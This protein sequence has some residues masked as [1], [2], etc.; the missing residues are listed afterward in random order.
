MISQLLA[1][2]GE[3]WNSDKHPQ[4]CEVVLVSA[5]DFGQNFDKNK[6]WNTREKEASWLK[7]SYLQSNCVTFFGRHFSFSIDSGQNSGILS[8][9]IWESCWKTLKRTSPIDSADAECYVTLE[10]FI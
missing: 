10:G 4:D 9:L 3:N 7:F 1:A 8:K 2:M 5:T 6:F